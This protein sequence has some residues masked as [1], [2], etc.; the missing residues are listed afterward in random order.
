MHTYR[1]LGESAYRAESGLGLATAGGRSPNPHFFRGFVEN[2]PQ[3][4]RAL[5]AVAEVARTRYFDAGAALRMRDPVVTSNRS[6]LRFESFSACN[7]V[8]AR[9]DLDDSGFSDDLADWGTTNVDVNDPLRAALS[10]VGAG[11]PLR[12]S[13]GADAVEVETMD[14]QIVERKVP[15][16]E[17]WLRGFAEVQ[18]ASTDLQPQIELPAARARVAIRDLPRQR[19]GNRM[20]WLASSSAGIRLSQ[21]AKKGSPAMVA[22]Q[23][24]A[25]LTRLGQDVRGL[26]I[27]AGETHSPNTPQATAWELQL[28]NARITLVISPELYRGFSGEGGV[29]RAMAESNNE[30]V[31]TVSSQLA[32]Q[33]RLDTA[34]LGVA[35][36]QLRSALGVLGAAGRV[37]FDLASDAFFHRDLPFDRSRLEGL[38]PRLVNA[39]KLIDECAVKL[40]SDNEAT[41]TSDGTRYAV[42]TSE[43]GFSCTCAWFAKHQDNRGACK[44][45]LAAELAR[46]GVTL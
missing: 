15:L 29:L 39:R 23:R 3:A 6:V 18:I 33:A 25:A 8:Y 43:D 2:A 26:K 19:T 30:A 17:R 45:V 13:V 36:D 40:T 31:E 14:D 16:P 4:A 32:G 35:S 11:E 5:L 34:S 27:Y 37:G 42:R 12:M 24:L 28:E 22:P 41:V 46:A 7:G 9:F 21:Q 1:Y 20:V 10:S 38:H 44:H